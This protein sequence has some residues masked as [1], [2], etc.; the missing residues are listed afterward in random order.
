MVSHDFVNFFFPKYIFFYR[1]KAQNTYFFLKKRCILG[2]PSVKGQGMAKD[3]F[4]F[5]FHYTDATQDG[6][7][8][9]GVPINKFVMNEMG[10]TN[11]KPPP[12]KK[13]RTPTNKR[14]HYEYVCM[15]MYVYTHTHVYIYTYIT[16]FYIYIYKYKCVCVYV[17]IYIYTGGIKGPSIR[18][19]QLFFF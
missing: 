13:K 18:L 11:P 4:F 6:T 14:F 10:G 12:T 8:S 15:Y 1:G 3:F 2:F 7:Q 9:K 16:F 19:L 5:F 17:C